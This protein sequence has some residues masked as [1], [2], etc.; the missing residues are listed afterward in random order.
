M[1]TRALGQGPTLL[2]RRIPTPVEY[3]PRTQLQSRLSTQ[4]LS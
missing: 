3:E 1:P 4:K 2:R